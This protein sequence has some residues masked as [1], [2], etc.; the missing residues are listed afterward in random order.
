MARR[1]SVIE[2]TTKGDKGVDMFP[3]EKTFTVAECRMKNELEG[4]RRYV[5]CRAQLCIRGSRWLLHV[6]HVKVRNPNKY[7][8]HVFLT[9]KKQFEPEEFKLHTVTLNLL[10]HPDSKEGNIDKL[11]KSDLHKGFELPVLPP[12]GIDPRNFKCLFIGKPAESKP[13]TPLPIM[14]SESLLAF[15]PMQWR[16]D[17]DVEDRIDELCHWR[18]NLREQLRSG[19]K[20]R[21]H[22]M[23]YYRLKDAA[24]TMFEMLGKNRFESITFEGM[25]A[26]AALL[27][28]DGRTVHIVDLLQSSSP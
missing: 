9:T 14:F 28:L 26:H 19:E 15:V 27:A 1:S 20:S 3:A 16:G 4:A 23:S 22:A 17:P 10:G 21:V 12:P 7:R 8:L 2:V 25:C 13:A 6:D 18:D 24:K 11:S 5:D